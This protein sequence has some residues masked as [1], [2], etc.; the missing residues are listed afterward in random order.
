[1]QALLHV[2][3]E[4]ATAFV[5]R[6]AIAHANIR[7]SVYRVSDGEQALGYLRRLEPY[8][9]VARPDLVFLDLDMPRVDGWQVLVAMRD[10]K[11]L[12]SIPVVVLTTSGDRAAKER[13][14]ALG[15]KHYITKPAAFD[16]LVGELTSA[17][18]KFFGV[19]T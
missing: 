18:Q 4:S 6:A 17:C 2:E 9:A 8:A 1:M 16:V 14:C 15:A 19:E 13:A 7:V 5:F 11:N 12:R 10:D 3:N